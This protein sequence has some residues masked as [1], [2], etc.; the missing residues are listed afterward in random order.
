MESKQLAVELLG[1]PFV[2]GKSGTT[3]ENVRSALVVEEFVAKT[4]FPT[5]A[6]MAREEGHDEIARLLENI[7][8]GESDHATVLREAL[9]QIEAS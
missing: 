5:L 2:Q 9:S 7:A 6:R 8:K 3:D 1:L 4:W